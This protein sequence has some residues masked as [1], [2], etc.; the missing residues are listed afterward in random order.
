M[1]L[2]SDQDSHSL[3][4]S[5]LEL[6]VQLVDADTVD[7]V[8]NALVV[9]LAPEDNSNV[10]G[11]EDVVVSWACAHWEFVSDVLLGDQ[12]LNFSPRQ[13]EDEPTILLDVVEFSVLG[14]DSKCAFRPGEK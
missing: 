7:E 6:F 12:E 1:S 4:Q 5:S 11:D 8:M 3:G 9:G 10:E 2:S 13:A 14:Y